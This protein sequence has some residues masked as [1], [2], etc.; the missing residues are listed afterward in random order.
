MLTIKRLPPRISPARK[1]KAGEI[2]NPSCRVAFSAKDGVNLIIIKTM[3]AV[4]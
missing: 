2:K 4:A 1:L 3:F